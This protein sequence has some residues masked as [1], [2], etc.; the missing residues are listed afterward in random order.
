M[1]GD[2]SQILYDNRAEAV[3]IPPYTEH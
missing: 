3:V 2:G 1:F